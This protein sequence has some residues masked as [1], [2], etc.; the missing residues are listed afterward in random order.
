MVHREQLLARIAHFGSESGVWF[1]DLR[2]A[3]RLAGFHERARGSHFVYVRR[4]HE[5]IFTLQARSGK[6]PPYQ[7]KQ[8]RSLVV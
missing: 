7:V 3:L 5:P 8:V 4:R 1:D 2:R 6:A